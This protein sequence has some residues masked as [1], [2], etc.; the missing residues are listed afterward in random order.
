MTI[1]RIA[2]AVSLACALG[3]CASYDAGYRRGYADG[4]PR[5]AIDA[6]DYVADS[7]DLD[8]VRNSYYD[9][10]GYPY[11]IAG[12]GG[13]WPFG[14]TAGP[15]FYSSW[16]GYGY[17]YAWYGGYDWYRWHH[18]DHDHDDDHDHDHHHPPGVDGLAGYARGVQ[19]MNAPMANGNAAHPP[20][21]PR[22]VSGY[23]AS[24]VP[25]R[26]SMYPRSWN[27]EPREPARP[28]PHHSRR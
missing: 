20:F 15:W 27:G 17:P 16:Y 19:R 6:G 25:P 28:A 22:D 23:P 11:E 21:N 1:H 26:M 4:H 9:D 5:V 7:T 3:G 8:D 10:Y 18:R 2:F 13:S 24:A 12:Y 14:Y